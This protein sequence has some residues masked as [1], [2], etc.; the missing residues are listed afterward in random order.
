MLKLPSSSSMT[1]S[2]HSGWFCLDLSKNSLVPR[3]RLKLTALWWD[4]EKAKCWTIWAISPS[5]T[6]SQR[7]KWLYYVWKIDRFQV[8]YNRISL[9]QNWGRKNG[10]FRSVFLIYTFL[11]TSWEH[12]TKTGFSIL[13][14]FTW[15]KKI[16]CSGLLM[17]ELWHF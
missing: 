6:E 13:I 2:K 7:I 10:F 3:E 4:T 15:G 5:V 1:S 14:F 11:E 9:N 12:E 17:N 8:K 16:G